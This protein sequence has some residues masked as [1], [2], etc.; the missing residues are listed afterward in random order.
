MYY[1][2]CIEDDDNEYKN[3]IG[4]IFGFDYIVGYGKVW[5]IIDCII[6]LFV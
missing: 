5:C 4:C 3:D 6:K 2:F 1:F